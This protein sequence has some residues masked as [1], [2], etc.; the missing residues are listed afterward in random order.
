M[1]KTE[2]DL[3]HHMFVMSLH[4]ALHLAPLNESIH[5]ALDIA[6]GTG[7]WAIEFGKAPMFQALQS[8]LLTHY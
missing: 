7:L 4:G 6:T 5:D 3:Q 1:T 8:T 2:T